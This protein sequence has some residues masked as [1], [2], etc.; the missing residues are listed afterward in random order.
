MLLAVC[1]SQWWWIRVGEIA[2]LAGSRQVRLPTPVC[3]LSKAFSSLDKGVYELGA[4]E[5]VEREYGSLR[6]AGGNGGEQG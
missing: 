5:G 3:T 6:G 4:G 2:G 1:R